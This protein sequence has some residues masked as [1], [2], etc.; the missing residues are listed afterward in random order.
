MNTVCTR[1]A[2]PRLLVGQAGAYATESETLKV[3][4]CRH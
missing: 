4:V 2:V 1:R 3:H